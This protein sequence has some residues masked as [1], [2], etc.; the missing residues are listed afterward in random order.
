MDRSTAEA[1]DRQDPLARFRDR[2]D[3]SEDGPVY[4][5]GNSLGRPPR[6]VSEAVEAG[7]KDWRTVL[8]SGWESWIELPAQVGDRLGRLL[9][10][11]EGQALVCD[12]TTVNLYKLASAALG[13][14]QDRPVIVGDASDFPTDRYVLEGLARATGRQLRLVD[15]GGDP[16]KAAEVISDAIGADTA[17]VC[18]SHVNYRSGLRLDVPALTAV[19]HEHGA[20]V[21]W[22]LAHSAGAVPMD[23]DGWGVDLAVGCTYKYLNS[24]PG[25]PGFLYVRQELQDDL[26]QPIWGWF[27]RASQFEMGPG[28]E[29]AGGV[30]SFMTGTPGVLGLMAVDASLKVIE[31]AGVDDLWRKSE[32]FTA[33]LVQLVDAKLAPFGARLAT[34]RSAELRGAHVS[35]SHPEAWAWCR[36]LVQRGLVVPDFRTPDVVRLG[37]APLYTRYVDCFDALQ[38]MAEVAAAGFDEV[39]APGRVT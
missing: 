35:V 16:A 17:L 21:L 2:F 29:P 6:D 19:A 23:L 22:D 14:R 30:A 36:T 26:R 39:A 4:M 13:V 27:G 15:T 11:A 1:M 31:E 3:I 10:A 24:G 18:L 37:P 34:P 38:R 8:V 28:Y 33:M 5:D 25:A 20:L 32:K 9:G 12:S 7:L